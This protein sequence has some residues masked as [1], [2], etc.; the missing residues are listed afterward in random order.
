MRLLY[1]AITNGPVHWPSAA[2]REIP[3]WSRSSRPSGSAARSELS[4]YGSAT[5]L[6]ASRLAF[7]SSTCPL[8]EASV[9]PLKPP[10]SAVTTSV[11]SP[12]SPAPSACTASCSTSTPR[13]EG[14]ESNPQELTIRAPAWRA[15]S[16]RSMHSRTNRTSPVRSA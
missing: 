1:G 2:S 12:S 5:T 13:S 6:R 7:I 10:F 11:V 4:A 15:R 14:I 9:P 16:W 3:I 8:T